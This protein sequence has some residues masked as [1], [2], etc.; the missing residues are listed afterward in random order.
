M[1][2]MHSVWP[3]ACFFACLGLSLQEAVHVVMA[4][5]A[6]VSSMP[7]LGLEEQ[8]SLQLRLLHGA[9]WSLGSALSIDVVLTLNNV[10]FRPSWR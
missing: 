1:A 6:S 10:G 7:N 8:L 9:L 2:S 5:L 3:V 4:L